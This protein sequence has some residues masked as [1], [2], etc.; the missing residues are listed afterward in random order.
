MLISGTRG[1]SYLNGLPGG[2]QQLIRDSNSLFG[3]RY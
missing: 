2:F 3:S 1:V